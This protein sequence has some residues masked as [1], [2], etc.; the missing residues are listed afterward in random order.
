MRA[1]YTTSSEDKAKIVA[2]APG[3]SALASAVLDEIIEATS[4]MISLDEWGIKAS[5]GHL[6][7]IAH[8]GTKALAAG[9]PSAAGPLQSRTVDKLSE[10][11][12]A[13]VAGGGGDSEYRSTSYGVEYLE[14][15]DSLLILPVVA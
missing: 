3:L 10:T 5:H 8:R 9:K 15:R 6:R 7:L 1:H 11:F 4:T 12:A 13:S 14:L 2:Y